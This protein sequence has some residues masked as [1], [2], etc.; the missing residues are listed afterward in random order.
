VLTRCGR[1][2][3]HCLIISIIIAAL[4]K[5][6]VSQKSAA[7]LLRA[8]EEQVTFLPVAGPS[9]LSNCVVVSPG[10]HFY[11]GL[12]RQEIIGSKATWQTFE[13]H[14]ND[15]EM[16]ILRDILTASDIQRLR[17]F[18]LPTTPFPSSAFEIFAADISRGPN[19]QHV[20]YFK[21]TGEGPRDPEGV[22]AAGGNRK[23]RCSPWCSGFVLLRL[24]NIPQKAP[25]LVP[26]FPYAEAPQLRVGHTK[27]SEIII[28]TFRGR[29]RLAPHNTRPQLNLRLFCGIM[30]PYAQG[31]HTYSTAPICWQAGRS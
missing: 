9:N 20:G 24:L 25:H 2:V 16:K 19:I 22:E 1:V 10:G 3:F 4:A 11:L 31:S 5:P 6:A 18:V 29:G 13:G 7:F 14:L 15:R 23:R 28:R 17:S 8:T 21:W 12:F 30:Y 27:T 26:G